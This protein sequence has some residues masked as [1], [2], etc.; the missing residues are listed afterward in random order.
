MHLLTRIQ[1][2]ILVSL[3][4]SFLIR[5]SKKI[6]LPGF[7]GI[8]LFDVIRFFFLQAKKNRVYRK[9]L[10]HCVQLYY[11]HSTG[12]NFSFYPVAL[13]AYFKR[14]Y[15]PAVPADKRYSTG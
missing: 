6:L 3:P 9:G 7:Q 5:K 12:G 11:D 8:P 13:P 2:R 1:R 10:G 4:V 14:F 15:Q